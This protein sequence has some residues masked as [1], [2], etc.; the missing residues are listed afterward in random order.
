MPLPQ[1]TPI[2]RLKELHARILFSKTDKVSKITNGSVVN[3][4]IYANA[5]LSQ[6]ALKDISLSAA[7]L[8]P[9][10]AHGVYLDTI[11]AHYGIPARY[12]PSTSSMYV[13]LIADPDTQYTAFGHIIT[14]D[15]GIQFELTEDVTVG[16]FGFAYGLCRS[17]TASQSANVTAG[18]VNGLS[19]APTGHTRISNEYAAWGG[20]DQESDDDFRTRIK[21][22]FNICSTGTYNKLTIALQQFEPTILRIMSHGL[23]QN[24]KLR[25]AVVNRSGVPFSNQELAD[26]RDRAFEYMSLSETNVSYLSNKGVEFVNVEW[27]PVDISM[28]V[29]MDASYDLEAVRARMHASITKL[30]DPRDWNQSKRVEWDDILQ[31]AKRTLGVEYVSDASFIPRVDLVVPPGMLPRVRMFEM[32]TLEGDLLYSEADNFSPVDYEQYRDYNFLVTVIQSL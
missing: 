27:F 23:N 19:S 26:L 30:F 14:S 13:R 5:K 8:F 7:H 2:E 6:K 20:R 3:A 28:R 9:D 12:G 31:V 21:D 18:S 29:R 24:G 1:Y 15:E 16:P 4:V 10:T 25:L 32:R 22:S 17:L 11:A